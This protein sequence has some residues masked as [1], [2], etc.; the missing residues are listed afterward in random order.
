MVEKEGS[1]KP[2]SFSVASAITSPLL[3]GNHYRGGH[4]LNTTQVMNV[5]PSTKNQRSPQTS[6]LAYLNETKYTSE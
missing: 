6:D 5:L 3:M 4:L 1:S 2:L